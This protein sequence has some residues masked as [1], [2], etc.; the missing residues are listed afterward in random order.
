MERIEEEER[1]DTETDSSP[2]HLDKQKSVSSGSLVPAT[3]S[4]VVS[5]LFLFVFV[6]C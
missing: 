2:Q 4:N 5:H 3:G 6:S 1:Q